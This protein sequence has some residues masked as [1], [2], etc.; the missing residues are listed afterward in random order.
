[1][2]WRE[3]FEY[4]LHDESNIGSIVFLRDKSGDSPPCTGEIMNKWNSPLNLHDV[5]LRLRNNF[6]SESTWKR[7]ISL[8]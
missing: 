8:F 7:K 4:S 1:M 3:D 6:A 5:W 2:K